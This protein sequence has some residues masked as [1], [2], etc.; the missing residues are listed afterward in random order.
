M[1]EGIK[2]L[3]YG[4]VL[5]FEIPTLVEIAT[6]LRRE[7]GHGAVVGGKNGTMAFSPLYITLTFEGVGSCGVEVF[8]TNKEGRCDWS[9]DLPGG[10]HG[11]RKEEVS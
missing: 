3:E 4:F 2:E 9:L 8:S 11:G 6:L 7:F 10:I 1:L 5:P